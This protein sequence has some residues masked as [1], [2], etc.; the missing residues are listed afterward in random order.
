MVQAQ[1]TKGLFGYP[2]TGMNAGNDKK[3]LGYLATQRYASEF[4]WVCVCI[5]IEVYREMRVVVLNFSIVY[6]QPYQLTIYFLKIPKCF[7][8]ILSY[9]YIYIRDTEILSL[10]LNCMLHH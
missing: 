1:M 2:L 7:L 3:L 5:V 10:K 4:M 9:K 6:T 8:P